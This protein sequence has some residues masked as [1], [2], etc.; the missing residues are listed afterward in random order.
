MIAPVQYDLNANDFLNKEEKKKHFL[1][2]IT[3]CHRK[4]KI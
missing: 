3:E 4:L 1:I 2:Q